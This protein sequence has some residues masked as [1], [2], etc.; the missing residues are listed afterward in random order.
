MD[1]VPPSLPHEPQVSQLLESSTLS[2]TVPPFPGGVGDGVGAGV[3]EGAENGVLAFD[4][5]AVGPPPHDIRVKVVR[6]KAAWSKTL[7]GGKYRERCKGNLRRTLSCWLNLEVY[8]NASGID[9]Y[10]VKSLKSGITLVQCPKRN[11]M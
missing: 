7:G 3:G 8:F 9:R 4:I 10:Y 6:I 1:P 5:P 11:L 2:I